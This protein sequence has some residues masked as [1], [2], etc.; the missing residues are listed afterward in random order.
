MLERHPE[1]EF[2]FIEAGCGWVPYWLWRL[3]E[4]YEQLGWEVRGTITMRP[5]DYFRRQCFVTWEPDEPYVQWVIDCVGAERVMVGSD[6]PHIDSKMDCYDRV[7]AA[8]D[9]IGR[10][11]LEKILWHNPCDFYGISARG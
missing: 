8:A 6:F 7:F 5:S 10:S 9:R 4:E 11:T 2:G 3:D 1:L